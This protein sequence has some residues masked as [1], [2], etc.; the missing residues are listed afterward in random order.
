VSKHRAKGTAFESL[1]CEGFKVL[2]PEAHR[3]G[4]QGAKDCGDIWLPISTDLVVE[5][6]SMSTYAGHLGT[7]LTE[8][9]VEAATAER[10][11]GVVV[12][13]RSGKG[14]WEDQYVTTD[15]ATFLGLM[16]RNRLLRRPD[17]T[18]SSSAGIP[19]S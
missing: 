7:W 2:W 18:D 12:H 11:F 1:I 8:A 5:A 10:M 19:R 16:G 6:K 13:K 4:V 14:N 3:L 15:L 17:G 9:Q